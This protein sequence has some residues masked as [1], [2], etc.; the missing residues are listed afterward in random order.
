MC[1]ILAIDEPQKCLFL[2]DFRRKPSFIF[3]NAGF[4]INVNGE[5]DRKLL[6]RPGE[7]HVPFNPGRFPKKW[8]CTAT[9][10]SFCS[11]MTKSDLEAGSL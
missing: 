11:D 8:N 6:R 9:K 3:L 10:L 4:I 5:R 2:V 1:V 7:I